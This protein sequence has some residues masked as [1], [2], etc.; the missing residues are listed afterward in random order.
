MKYL[1]RSSNS[2]SHE[3]DI[4]DVKYVKSMLELALSKD[5]TI[6]G[7]FKQYYFKLNEDIVFT[8]ASTPITLNYETNIPTNRLGF[9][10]ISSPNGLIGRVQNKN[11]VIFQSWMNPANVTWPLEI[12]VYASIFDASQ[13]DVIEERYDESLEKFSIGTIYINQTAGAGIATNLD[14]VVYLAL[15]ETAYDDN[16]LASRQYVKDAV[17]AATIQSGSLSFDTVYPVGSTYLTFSSTFNPNTTWSG[18]TWVQLEEF[19]QL[20][21]KNNANSISTLYMWQRTA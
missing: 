13:L 11:T 17:N 8:D 4:A 20:A 7:N 14:T 16:T 6:L 18:T 9:S 1:G 10:A 21:Q 12:N 2:T 5:R 3:T 15:T 19:V